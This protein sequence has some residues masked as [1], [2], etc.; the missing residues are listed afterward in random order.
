MEEEH[1]IWLSQDEDDTVSDSDEDVEQSGEYR[2]F[3]LALVNQDG[4]EG[5]ESS[6]FIEIGGKKKKRNFILIFWQDIMFGTKRE[7]SSE[8]RSRQCAVGFTRRSQP[9]LWAV[10]PGP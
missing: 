1:E 6:S 4:Q 2:T 3:S 10:R 9:L 8:R 7:C 5:G